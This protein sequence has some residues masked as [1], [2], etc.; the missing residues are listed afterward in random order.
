M[1]NFSKKQQ[2]KEDNQSFSFGWDVEK[3]PIFFNPSSWPVDAGIPI[4]DRYALVRDD[5]NKCLSVVSSRYCPF[6][7][8]RF[9]GIVNAYLKVGSKNPMKK[10]FNGGGK[11]SVQLENKSVG[12]EALTS[13]ILADTGSK[14][15]DQHNGYITMINGHDT[16]T[17]WLFG[18][19]IV[20]IY[21]RNTFLIAMKD[22]NESAIFTGKHL[23]HW[24][25]KWE[26]MKA[27]VQAA[28]S[29]MQ[30]FMSDIEQMS[31]QTWD[32]QRNTKFFSKVF[33]I[34]G[35]KQSKKFGTMLWN[36]NHVYDMYA[37][38]YGTDNKYS[39]FNA[40]THIVDHDSTKKQKERGWNQIGRG[41]AIKNRA[42]KLL[43][44]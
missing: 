19:T 41:Q 18:L 34:G 42:F 30:G 32:P 3:R 27:T 26:D 21:C 25:V 43:T 1:T 37:D 24:E 36:F 4:A 35:K 10:E 8:K 31:N 38:Q 20:R 28:S 14:I 17:P 6:Y 16:R 29:T 12:S 9:E 33:Q 22:L 5:N 15:D 40:V 11:L 39:V 23:P 44:A 7:N 13:Q 2:L